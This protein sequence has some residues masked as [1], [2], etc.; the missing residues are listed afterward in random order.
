MVEETDACH[1][2]QRKDAADE[3]RHQDCPVGVIRDID[4]EVFP[5]EERRNVCR[6][7]AIEKEQQAVGG[8]PGADGPDHEMASAAR[9]AS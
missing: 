5:D 8:D 4:V 7:G 2:A 6:E 1:V 3:E 9:P